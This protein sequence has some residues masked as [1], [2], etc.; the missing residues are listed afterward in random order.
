MLTTP[1]PGE[2]IRADLVREI[3]E[4]VRANT[5]QAGPG[6][7]VD[8]GPSGTVVSIQGEAAEQRHLVMPDEIVL[9]KITGGTAAGGYTVALH[10][11]GLH[12][13]STGTGVLHVPECAA[14]GVGNLPVGSVVIAH[15]MALTITGG[16]V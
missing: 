13:E 10:A 3:V 12:A 15:V 11:D 5:V 9:A 16:G 7:L 8:R 4:A 1:I 14:D 2:A 6:I